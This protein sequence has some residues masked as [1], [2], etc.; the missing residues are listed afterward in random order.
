MIVDDLAFALADHFHPDNRA[1]IE[2][3]CMGLKCGATDCAVWWQSFLQLEP[4]EISKMVREY[5]EKRWPTTIATWN[6]PRKQE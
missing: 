5:A 1:T 3:G 2:C 4:K 6:Y